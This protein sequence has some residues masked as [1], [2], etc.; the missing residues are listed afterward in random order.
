MAS[1]DESINTLKRDFARQNLERL[2]NIEPPQ[3]PPP[4]G[5]ASDSESCQ[6]TLA[7]LKTWSERNMASINKSVSQQSFL[8]KQDLDYRVAYLPFMESMA[9]YLRDWGKVRTAWQTFHDVNKKASYGREGEL[10]KQNA[11][12]NYLDAQSEID[13]LAQMWD[14][15]FIQICDLIHE[16]PIEP[17]AKWF[18]GP[19]CG[20]F[21]TTEKQSSAPFIGLAFKGTNPVN[22]REVAVDY[23]YDLTTASSTYLGGK[24]VSSGV[25]AALF[26]EFES[27]HEIAY[28]Y[29]VEA[30]IKAANI[31]PGA[32]P[33]LHV[34]GHSLGGSYSS[35]AYAQL[36]SDVPNFPK[37]YFTMGDEYT[38][39]APRVGS[40]DWAIYNGNM[41]SKNPGLTYRI[42][43]NDD[44]VP[45]IPPTT[46]KKN[47]TD[48]Y[49]VDGGFRIYS[50]KTPTA[51]PSEI[52]G[53]PPEP[54]PIPGSLEK[55][56]ELILDGSD[57]CKSLELRN[58]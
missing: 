12:D 51:I 27:V 32:N 1:F 56:I 54:Y 25:F 19:Y 28:S 17:P 23:D 48:F 35:F 14:M 30:M 7:I 9:V 26:S 49:H 37:A 6:L 46:L 40:Q 3:P 34:T 4:G 52:G 11:I 39:G 58:S 53:P 10:L 21:I 15:K 45:Q 13:E 38:F 55:F 2:A 29:I 43:N 24:P 18:C 50:D 47:Q 20:I 8:N 41:V 57:H 31:V 44:M 5:P 22:V 33:R 42:V 36:L 16:P